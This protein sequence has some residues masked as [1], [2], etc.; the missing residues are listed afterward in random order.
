MLKTSA[1]IK[2]ADRVDS[3]SEYE[4][5]RKTVG[6]KKKLTSPLQ[7]ATVE[8]LYNRDEQ[9]GK[10]DQHDSFLHS[11]Q[12]IVTDAALKHMECLP[13][14]DDL[15]S[16]PN[17]KERSKAITETAY[18]KHQAVTAYGACSINTNP[19]YYPLS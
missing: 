5:N 14:M 18:W 8:I 12:S 10:W 11:K 1:S 15:D 7:F 2:S 17:I 16:E 19:V 9:L 13:T 3:K 4:G 6:T